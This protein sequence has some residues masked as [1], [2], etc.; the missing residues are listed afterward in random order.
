MGNKSNQW[1]LWSQHTWITGNAYIINNHLALIHEL[2]S[3]PVQC[4]VSN[5]YQDSC[6][7]LYNP[8]AHGAATWLYKPEDVHFLAIRNHAWEEN[9]A[10]WTRFIGSTLSAWCLVSYTAWLK[11]VLRGKGVMKFI[12][13]YGTLAFV[14]KEDLCQ[15]VG[16][17]VASV[18]MCLTVS[19]TELSWAS[20]IT[21]IRRTRLFSRSGAL[22]ILFLQ[23]PFL[24]KLEKSQFM[25]DQG[26]KAWKP[27]QLMG[28]S[29]HPKQW[30]GGKK[31]SDILMALYWIC[32]PYSGS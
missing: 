21:S 25:S 20:V 23:C 29:A 12:M 4:G 7:C 8:E 2:E 27:A 22:H 1:S 11:W 5:G 17:A 6:T 14:F 28:S 15:Y 16:K 3:S 31:L 24:S 26:H 30:V 18:S 32:C 13:T 9:W 10:V 19:M